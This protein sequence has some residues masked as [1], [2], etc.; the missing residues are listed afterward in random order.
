MGENPNIASLDQNSF[1]CKITIRVANRPPITTNPKLIP[2]PVTS[3]KQPL[4]EHYEK[5]NPKNMKASSI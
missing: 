1:C 2:S 3:P 5:L 4:K